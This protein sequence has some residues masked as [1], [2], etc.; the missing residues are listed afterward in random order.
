MEQSQDLDSDSIQRLWRRLSE[1]NDPFA[2]EAL[3]L[4][5][6]QFANMVAATLYAK[7]FNEEIEFDD[8]VQWATLGLIE[9]LDR[10][11]PSRGVQFKNFALRRMHGA[12]LDGIKSATEKQQ[13][14]AL[15]VRLRKERLDSIR[16]K[17]ERRPSTP[18]QGDSKAS[19]PESALRYLAE[20]ATG[21]A[22]AWLL[23]DTGMVVINDS[24]SNSHHIPYLQALEMKQLQEQVRNLVDGL[25]TQQQTVIRGHYMDEIPFEQI[26]TKLGLTRGRISQIHKQAL[27]CLRLG[28]N[29]QPKCNVSL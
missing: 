26:A 7:R 29:G 4:H 25:P 8:Y 14:I 5:H 2:R 13:Q 9:S 21:L 6:M 18:P 11:D 20:V 27:A 24:P 17:S 10:F 12:I 19:K 22:L 1:D 28:L 23:E 15:R 3:V 16:H